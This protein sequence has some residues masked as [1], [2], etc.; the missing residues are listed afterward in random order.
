[1]T[2]DIAGLFTEVRRLGWAAILQLGDFEDD[3]T[4]GTSDR[5]GAFVW[6]PWP[7]RDPDV[8]D[9]SAILPDRIDWEAPDEFTGRDAD[10]LVALTIAMEQA[11][12]DW[13]DKIE[14]ARDDRAAGYGRLIEVTD[15]R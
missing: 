12:K 13:A 4:A 14:Q 2:N 15:E 5:F 6:V 3:Y 9:A 8:D 11:R 1:M 7:S 10:P